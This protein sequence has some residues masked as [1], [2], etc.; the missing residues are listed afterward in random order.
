[1]LPK[2]TDPVASVPSN[3]EKATNVDQA[4]VNGDENAEMSTSEVNHAKHADN[5]QSGVTEAD[6][7]LIQTP[8]IYEIPPFAG[9][10]FIIIS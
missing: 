6:L 4:A 3:V 1:M 10:G 9:K 7:S 8:E 2:V 5:D